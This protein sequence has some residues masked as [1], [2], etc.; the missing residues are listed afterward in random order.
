MQEK[1]YPNYVKRWG[2]LPWLGWF[3]SLGL[4]LTFIIKR[5]ETDNWVFAIGFVLSIILWIVAQ[6]IRGLTY[7]CPD[8]HQFLGNLKPRDLHSE[9]LCICRR[10][11]TIWR[12]GVRPS[13]YIPRCRPPDQ[14]GK[15]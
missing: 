4:F 14:S 15:T 13:D 8:C 1:I 3:L 9:H 2:W 12:T 7:R 6:V 10:C 5:D 11:Q